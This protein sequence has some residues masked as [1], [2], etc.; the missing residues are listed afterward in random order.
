MKIWEIRDYGE[1]K[2][3]MKQLSV[4]KAY[5]QCCGVKGGWKESPLFGLLSSRTIP[6]IHQHQPNYTSLSSETREVHTLPIIQNIYL[7]HKP[8]TTIKRN[9]STA[10]IE[11]MANC[12][13]PTVE[14]RINT[15]LKIKFDA[16]LFRSPCLTLV[17]LLPLINSCDLYTPLNTYQFITPLPGRIQHCQ[18]GC[19][20]IPLCL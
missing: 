19:Y 17:I 2:T 4:Y 16:E 1:K 15:N 14:T 8:L 20:A 12:L 18:V 10:S 11:K 13:M 3:M 9:L 6:R 5:R 7:L